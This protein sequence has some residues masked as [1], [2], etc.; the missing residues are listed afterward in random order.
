[1][2]LEEG[3]LMKR[4]ARIVIFLTL[5]LLVTAVTGWADTTSETF[6][7]TTA[8]TPFTIDSSAVPQFDPTLGTL[9]SIVIDVTGSDSGTATI[10]NNS[11]ASG[12]YT[13]TIGAE[14]VLE[15]P[16]LTP[17]ITINPAFTGT[18]PVTHGTTVTSPPMTS[19]P[20]TGT[21]TLL[22]GFGAY[23]GTGTYV[24]TL[25][26]NSTGSVSGLTPF[27]VTESTSGS[28]SGT[29][30]YNFTP[31]STGTVPEPSSIMLFGTGLTLLGLALRRFRRQKSQS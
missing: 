22:S 11:A 31:A 5:T 21:D 10:A 18:V 23:T 4:P 27:T 7:F 30:T 19:G 16:S 6:S 14:L 25:T 2:S 26:G 8:T 20:V 12:T 13:F 17:L 28:E 1:M 15:D 9:T 3:L 29:V 24:F